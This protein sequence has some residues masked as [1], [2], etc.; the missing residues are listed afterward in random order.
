MW[1]CWERVDTKLC[2]L[3]HL[4]A[5]G[6][7]GGRWAVSVM[8]CVCIRRLGLTSALRVGDSGFCVR[9]T[10]PKGSPAN[11]LVRPFWRGTD[12]EA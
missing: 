7:V 9:T 11:K 12:L 2:N 1:V 3:C 5:S 4:D 6:V 8:G 10:E